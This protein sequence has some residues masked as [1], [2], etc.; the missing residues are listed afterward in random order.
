LFWRFTTLT[1]G[2]L[3]L[4]AC[5]SA[6]EDATIVVPPEL[7]DDETTDASTD[8]EDDDVTAEEEEDEVDYTADD[9]VV[10]DPSVLAVAA[11]IIVDGLSATPADV[12]AGQDLSLT[13]TLSN[14]GDLPAGSF[15]VGFYLSEDDVIEP[16]VDVRLCL[17]DVLGLEVDETSTFWSECGVPS[18]ATGDHYV[19]AFVDPDGEL[20]EA[21]DTNND[22]VVATEISVLPPTYA[23]LVPELELVTS[24]YDVG[25]TLNVRLTMTNLGDDVSAPADVDIYVSEESAIKPASYLACT[26]TVAT[27]LSPNQSTSFMLPVDCEV[28]SFSPGDYYVLAFADPS[29]TVDESDEANNFTLVDGLTVMAPPSYDLTATADAGSYALHEGDE[30]TWLVRVH[31]LGSA[32]VVGTVAID[33]YYSVDTT[34]TSADHFICSTS[35]MGPFPAGGVLS[36]PVICE[37]PHTPAGSMYFGAIVDSTH[38][39]TETNENNNTAVD[40]LPATLTPNT[41]DLRVYNVNGTGMEQAVPGETVTVTASVENLGDT[42]VNTFTWQV[43]L[44]T[45]DVVDA[46]DTWVCSDILAIPLL[47]GQ[48]RDLNVTCE[49]PTGTGLSYWFVAVQADPG[50]AVDEIDE[51]NNAD[52]DPIAVYIDEAIVDLQVTYVWQNWAVASILFGS[53]DADFVVDVYNAGPD[54]V[55]E[56]VLDVYYSTDATIDP[57]VDAHA[58]RVTQAWALEGNET[59]RLTFACQIP[60]T[61]GTYYAGA[62]LDAD[63]NVDETIETNNWATQASSHQIIF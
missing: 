42:A 33:L 5:S 57:S 27:A 21:D 55:Q 34:I 25:D 59:R 30:N 32:D 3:I 60:V 28:P 17:V 2:F 29:D 12:A 31:N 63:D 23:D 19:G 37:V 50:N 10:D 47:P 36:I 7:L 45:D 20:A 56:I 46:M 61:L 4:S 41:Y 35:S 43:L 44:S 13:Y 39:L 62:I 38:Q 53:P 8:S 16:A 22:F 15:R 14:I 54:P 18:F 48:S 26:V 24:D 49:V 40:P 51:T 58:C 52:V 6:L 1:G 11:D 9:K